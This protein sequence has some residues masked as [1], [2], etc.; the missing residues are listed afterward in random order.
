MSSSHWERIREQH[1]LAKC[2]LRQED[3]YQTQSTDVTTLEIQF[4]EVIRDFNKWLANGKG[5]DSD[6]PYSVFVNFLKKRVSLTNTALKI[7]NPSNIQVNF[8]DTQVTDIIFYDNNWPSWFIT[9]NLKMLREASKEAVRK[10][11]ALSNKNA[12]P[13]GSYEPT[14]A[15]MDNIIDE[16]NQFSFK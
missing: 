6:H 12:I 8:T 14:F 11:L 10:E 4:Q 2:K 16:I 5:R 9:N 15:R 3:M 1:K 7:I 13:D